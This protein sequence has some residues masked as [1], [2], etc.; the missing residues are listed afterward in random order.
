[1][2]LLIVKLSSLGDVVHA[3]PTLAA[4]RRASPDAHIAWLV[5]PA[6]AGILAGHPML[7]A[8]FVWRGDATP[9]APH[10]E[11]L[12][13]TLALA[14]RLRAQRFDAALDLQGLLRSA[15]LAYLSGARRRVGFRNFQEGAFLFNT[16]RA[17]SDRKDIHAVFGYLAF[18][19]HLGA[20][21]DVIEFPFPDSPG[22]G[23]RLDALLAPAAGKPLVALI[24]DASWPTKRWP[25]ERFALVADALADDGAA[26]VIIGGDASGPAADE[27]LRRAES[28]PINAAGR[29][30]LPDLPALFR[31]CALAVAND[32]G[33]MHIAAAVGRPVVALFG[34]TSPVRTG[35][36]GDG[37]AVIRAPVPCLDCHR[38]RC[39]DLRCM[40]GIPVDQVVDAARRMLRDSP[41]PPGV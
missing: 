32:S 31:R 19:A 37:H 41:R 21:T 39:S 4:L 1:M 28:H 20:P 29:T 23:K 9:A 12:T 13:S 2:R 26:C 33:P 30:L 24:P 5:G 38:R 27:I 36:F 34:P 16:E 8:T 18:A 7:D 3:L 40:T 10:T 14:R 25:T 15:V 35:P 11:A 22:A 17:I 6:A